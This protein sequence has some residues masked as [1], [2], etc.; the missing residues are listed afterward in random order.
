MQNFAPLH[1]AMRIFGTCLNN[2]LLKL[3]LVYVL[4][5]QAFSLYFYVDIR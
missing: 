1:V 3:N 2:M 5:K 4:P